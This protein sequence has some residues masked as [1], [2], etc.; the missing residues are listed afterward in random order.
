MSKRKET[1]EGVEKKKILRLDSVAYFKE[2]LH[3]AP[4]RLEL[5]EDRIIPNLRQWFPSITVEKVKHELDWGLHE[6]VHA[7]DGT[8]YIPTEYRA[9][10]LS[11]LEIP[12][13]S[14]GIVVMVDL[15]NDEFV[16][17]DNDEV[18][19]D[20]EVSRLTD[21]LYAADHL[22]GVVCRIMDAEEPEEEEPEAEKKPV[23]VSD[24]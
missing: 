24:K 8:R 5:L 2:S 7:E 23:S 9:K 16:V 3:Q 6:M 21:E 11:I 22:Y 14:N 1:E 13:I 20:G 15:L 19:E 4:Q 17:L 10:G 12:D 18:I